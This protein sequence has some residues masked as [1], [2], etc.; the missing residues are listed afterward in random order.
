MGFADAP[1]IGAITAATVLV[2]E[3]G[4]TARSVATESLNR[5]ASTGGEAIGTILNKYD[6]KAHGFSYSSYGYYGYDYSGGS[7]PKRELIAPPTEPK[8][9]AA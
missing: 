8:S 9:R 5:L 3:S 1:L 6:H 4:S 2:V 7:K